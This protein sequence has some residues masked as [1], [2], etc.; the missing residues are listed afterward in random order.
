MGKHILLV[1]S[2]LSLVAYSQSSLFEFDYR[3]FLQAFLSNAKQKEITLNKKCFDDKFMG[4]LQRAKGYLENGQ[5]MKF[6]LALTKLYSDVTESCPVNEVISITKKVRAQLKNAHWVT[7]ET[8][9]AELFEISKI[10]VAAFKSKEHSA[11][12]LG[13][14]YGKIV[15]HFLKVEWTNIVNEVIKEIPLTEFDF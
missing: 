9:P 10:I 2:L 13:T 15:Y 6:T 12:E 1:L 4:N 8:I 14:I 5:M 11:E 3:D 7:A